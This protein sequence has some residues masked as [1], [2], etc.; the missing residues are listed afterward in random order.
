MKLILVLHIGAG[1]VSLIVG[2]HALLSKKG[3]K[4]H[5]L[6][7]DIFLVAMLLI[8]LSGLSLSIPAENL[9]LT[10]IALFSLYQIVSGKR[11]IRLRNN[12]AHMLD[13]TWAI[14]GIGNGV[15]MVSS[16]FPLAIVFGLIQ[17]N[18]AF[19]DL[20]FFYKIVNGISLKPR[21]Y[22]VRHIGL[23]VGALIAST[24]AF[25]IVNLQFIEWYWIPWLLPT[26]LLVPVIIFQSK[27]VERGVS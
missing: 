17:L 9:Y 27:K 1:I 2:Y 4:R 12:K 16:L 3:S 23:M 8:C 20:R 13:W 24:T 19:V 5:K 6:S 18:L 10:Q 25:F 26:F 7:G 22:L 21:A 11:A 15:W 14:M